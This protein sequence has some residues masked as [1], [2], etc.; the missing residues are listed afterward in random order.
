MKKKLL[1]FVAIFIVSGVFISVHATTQKV[2]E[3]VTI[4][5]VDNQSFIL[6]ADK[7][8][9]E[10]E[11]DNIDDKANKTLKA[12]AESAMNDGLFPN[13]KNGMKVHIQ[14]KTATVNFSNEFI[15][16]YNGG[17]ISEKMTMYSIINTLTSMPEIKR[18]NFLVDGKKDGELA[19][20]M[21]LN[22]TYT[23]ISQF[24]D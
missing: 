10:Y 17:S 24:N 2:R 3:T 15:K 13:V 19:G 6:F 11:K 23:F 20:H 14:D 1:F 8:V 22:K 16:K 4:Y 21:D 7:A 5:T 9:I 18:V 12:L